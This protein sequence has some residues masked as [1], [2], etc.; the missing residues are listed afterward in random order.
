MLPGRPLE[1][2]G[3]TGVVLLRSSWLRTCRE[4][5][6][7]AM[8]DCQGDYA[9]RRIS[10]AR[11]LPNAGER[12]LRAG[13]SPIAPLVTRPCHNSGRTTISR[14][15]RNLSNFRFVVSGPNCEVAN[16]RLH[17]RSLGLPTN[18]RSVISVLAS[19]VCVLPLIHV[20]AT[21]HGQVSR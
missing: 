8:P 11:L 21:P 2:S 7:V 1:P 16:E 14:L 9:S 17:R 19:Q 12:V 6:S 13:C 5:I 15:L 20:H 3:T 18:W 10:D 4:G